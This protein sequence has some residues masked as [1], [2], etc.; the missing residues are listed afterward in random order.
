MMSDRRDFWDR[1]QP[2]AWVLPLW[3]RF[4]PNQWRRMFRYTAGSA[5]CFGVS[6]I[7]F[8]VLF[9]P[10]VLGAKSSSVVASVAGII[11]GYWLNRT[12]TWGRRHRS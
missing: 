3:Q 5:I 7:T 11:P 12:W 9:A 8:V 2:P 6:E 4:S 1:W 10:H